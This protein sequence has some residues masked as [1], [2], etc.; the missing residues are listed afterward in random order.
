MYM[1]VLLIAM[2]LTGAGITL[3]SV[4]RADRRIQGNI[5][6]GEQ[7]ALTAQTGMEWLFWDVNNDADWRTTRV[8]PDATT[9]E[10]SGLGTLGMKVADPDGDFADD[11]TDQVQLSVTASHGGSSQ[12]LQAVATP[13][14]HP[15]LQFAVFGNRDVSFESNATVAGPIRSNG[16]IIAYSTVALTDNA[17][18]QTVSGNWISSSL[19]PAG[20][21]DQA[22]SFPAPDLAFYANQATVV[23]ASGNPR[24]ISDVN[25]TDTNNTLGTANPKGIYWIDAGG[26][27]LEI[28]WTHV[29]GTLIITNVYSYVWFAEPCWIEPGDAG[30]PTIIVYAP[31]REVW[32]AMSAGELDEDESSVDFNEDG[33]TDD[34]FAPS[35][36]G[37]VWTNASD[38]W[39]RGSWSLTGCAIGNYV[40]MYNGI[41]IDDDPDLQDRLV[42]GFTDGKLHL[43]P[44]SIREVA[45]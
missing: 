44:G 8:H 17:A 14:T 21:T 40:H 2:L 3:I 43:V 7:A 1:A 20:Y 32:I 39:L 38:L 9:L 37:V 6:R 29:R 45:P 31:G 22:M 23:S 13:K 12:T 36:G 33:D 35:V 42:P 28:S 18:F 41:R 16:D 26:Y 24:S 5:G 25:L 10:V 4:Q 27:D 34:T 15:A 19:E 30:Y 11:D